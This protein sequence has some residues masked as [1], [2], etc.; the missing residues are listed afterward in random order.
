VNVRFA[1]CALV[2]LLLAGCASKTGFE[3]YF[4]QDGATKTGPMTYQLA[5]IQLVLGGDEATSRYPE[6][7]ALQASFQGFLNEQLIN[8]ELAG[9][10]YELSV[11]VKWGRRM[12]GKEGSSKDVFSSATC[13]FEATIS[14]EGELIA[15]DSGDPLNAQTAKYNNKNMFNNLKRIGDS[16]SRSGDPDS[17][18]RELKRCAKLLAER[19]PR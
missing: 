2:V 12:I 19:L 15:S 4:P 5:D 3:P 9:A 11:S 16:V 8:R 13:W 6:Q 14:K 7:E 10:E 1:V 18:Q 17:E